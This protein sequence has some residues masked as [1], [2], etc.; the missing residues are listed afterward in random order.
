MSRDRTETADLTGKNV[1]KAAELRAEWDRWAARAKVLP[2]ETVT[3]KMKA[4]QKQS[5]TAKEEL[6]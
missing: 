1:T 2:W 5:R 3:A 4:Q 6:P